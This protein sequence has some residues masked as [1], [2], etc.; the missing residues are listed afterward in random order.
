VTIALFHPWFNTRGGAEK[1]VLEWLKRTKHDVNVY[2]WAYWPEKTFEELKEFN[3]KQI[4]P[5]WLA[6]GKYPFK[7]FVMGGIGALTKFLDG[8]DTLLVSTAGIAELALLANRTTVNA[9]YVHT[10]LRECLSED[11]EWMKR[12]IFRVTANPKS[13]IRRLYF[14]TSTRIYNKLE[15]K[16]WNRLN[17]VAFNSSLTLSRAQQKGL[18]REDME[19]QVIWPGVELPK[20]V[21]D[22][23]D[24][25]GRV[26]YLSRFGHAKRQLEL[27]RAWKRIE[28][29]L[30]QS[31]RLV[32]AGAGNAW[33]YIAKVREEAQGHR[34]EI[35]T[36]LTQEEVAREY[37]RAD[38]CIF[39][40]RNE[41]FG[42]APLEA[43]AWGKPL[44]TVD[45]GGFWDV[46]NKINAPGVLPV[47]E[48]S[49]IVEETAKGLIYMFQYL[50]EWK[51][52][53]K[54]NAKAIRNI[55]LS[56][57]RFSRELDRFLM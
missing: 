3:I 2:T 5:N 21:E 22:K 48:G 39:L 37:A 41:D 42:I 25:S 29:D 50:D 36:D 31:A 57:E 52:L 16:A 44:L 47:R 18:I 12:E 10:P 30:P 20:K 45:R 23:S 15:R 13:W 38:I 51:E 9:A 40:G 32:L 19:T 4:M 33:K 1:L 27:V 26:L 8:E 56:W 6:K 53:G 14:E 28:Q 17:R 24:G 43:L 46:L 11:R 35:M 54:N 34:I 7:G 49:T 55:D